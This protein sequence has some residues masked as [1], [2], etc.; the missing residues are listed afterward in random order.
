V[1][2]GGEGLFDIGRMYKKTPRQMLDA[3]PDVK[4]SKN[5]WVFVGQKICI[6]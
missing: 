3:N 5:Q 2:E 4:N 1:V 6:P